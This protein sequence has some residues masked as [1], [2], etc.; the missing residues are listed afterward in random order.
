MARRLELAL[1]S[2]IAVLAL[3]GCPISDD[4]FIEPQA[5]GSGG[6]SGSGGMAGKAG[7]GD[8]GGS[9]GSDA[10]GGSGVV[11]GGSGGLVSG[12]SGGSGG[13]P[14]TCEEPCNAPRTCE[15]ECQDGWITTSTPP[16]G[17]SPREKAAYTSIGNQIFIWGGVN[18]S[19]TALNSGALY[20]PRTDTWKVVA[21]DGETPTPRSLATAVWTGSDI[22]VWGGLDPVTMEPLADGAIYDPVADEWAPMSPGPQARSAPVGAAIGER[23]VFFGGQDDSGPLGGLDRYDPD[24]DDWEAGMSGSN[25]PAVADPAVAGGTVTL[26][27]YGGRTEFNTGVS[28]STYYSMSSE[29]WFAADPRAPGRW[30]SFSVFAGGVFFVWGGRNLNDFFDDGAAYDIAASD[31]ESMSSFGAPSA[32][33]AADRESGWAFVMNPETND[34]KIL[35]I[36]GLEDS[37]MYLTDGALYGVDADSWE[38]IPAWPSPASHVFGA[39]G[40]A[41]GELIVWGG[42]DGSTLTNQ[43]VRY[44]PPD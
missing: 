1:A 23:I 2:L 16:G 33:F 35:I 14:T 3:P 25:P 43:G 18:E 36:A 17:F 34:E 39:A 28:E 22:I 24:M 37:G 8:K 4:F 27:T 30:G 6:A 32:R 21:N 29:R 5:T 20:D 15:N 19:G 13:V 42:R 40:I 9:A 10:T 38:A 31:W 26:W 41:A 12:G 7:K 11:S 44:R